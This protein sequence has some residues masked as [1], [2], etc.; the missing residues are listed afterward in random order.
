M[1]EEN[2]GGRWRG[3]AKLGA[4]AAGL[5]AAAERRRRAA[6]SAEA[7][8]L[9]TEQAVELA[10]ERAALRTAE[11]TARQLADRNAPAAGAAPAPP[12]GGAVR[13]DDT[14]PA[15]R[16]PQ[17]PSTSSAA[18]RSAAPPTRSTPCPGPCGSP[19]SPPGGCC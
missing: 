1:T 12:E 19:P 3:V 10:A 11:Q 15:P 14:V 4:V 18:P 16:T 7:H 8:V 5:F 2:G 6:I 9:A 13:T 17:P